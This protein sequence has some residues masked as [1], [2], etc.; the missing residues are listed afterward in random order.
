MENLRQLHTYYPDCGLYLALLGY[1]TQFPMLKEN[2]K[3]VA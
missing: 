1:K 2:W 3:N